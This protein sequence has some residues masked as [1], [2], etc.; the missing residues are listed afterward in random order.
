VLPRSLRPALF[1]LTL[2]EHIQVEIPPGRCLHPRSANRLRNLCLT[3]LDPY[4]SGLCEADRKA[5]Q[6]YLAAI[7]PGEAAIIRLHELHGQAATGMSVSLNATAIGTSRD[8]RLIGAP[9][10]A[11]WPVLGRVASIESPAGQGVILRASDYERAYEDA[12]R[13]I[14]STP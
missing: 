2:N 14:R 10:T 5:I 9:S 12:L 13:D 3:R 1:W 4:S 7:D 6:R 11:G 8:P